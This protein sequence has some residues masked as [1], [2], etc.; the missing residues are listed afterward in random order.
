MLEKLIE[1]EIDLRQMGA[2]MSGKIAAVLHGIESEL[3]VL[4]GL[5]AQ[6]DLQTAKYALLGAA[7]DV[8]SVA[9]AQ[10]HLQELYKR[11]AEKLSKIEKGE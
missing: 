2:E 4:A 10:E 11:S 6:N 9:A 3:Q 8:S 7:F 1:S 5:L